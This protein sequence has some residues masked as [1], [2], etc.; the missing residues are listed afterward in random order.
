MN[1]QTYRV[2]CILLDSQALL[3]KWEFY[4]FQ[5]FKLKQNHIP[6]PSTSHANPYTPNQFNLPF[7]PIQN[8]KKSQL[9]YIFYA[10]EETINQFCALTYRF[11]SSFKYTN[12]TKS[13]PSSRI[14]T[15]T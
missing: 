8:P 10:H 5:S 12:E 2:F 7:K 15:N 6:V 14:T 3:F 11:K 9:K 1:V 4:M 13:S